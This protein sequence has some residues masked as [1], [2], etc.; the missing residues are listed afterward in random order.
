MKFKSLSPGIV[1]PATI[2]FLIWSR[3]ALA[4]D[5]LPKPA[6]N[7]SGTRPRMNQKLSPDDRDFS[8]WPYNSSRE[9]IELMH[10]NGMDKN[11]GQRA[12]A[13]IARF[14]AGCHRMR[15]SLPSDL[16][17][18]PR[19]YSLCRVGHRKICRWLRRSV[20]N[21]YSSKPRISMKAINSRR[22]KR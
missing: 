17:L 13:E 12:G 5:S 1:L 10:G 3:P 19:N 22:G 8:L 4:Q 9:K 15:T 2:A 7:H 21:G 20:S 16:K 6:G 18:V 11:T 14:M